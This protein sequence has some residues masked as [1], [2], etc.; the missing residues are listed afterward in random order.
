MLKKKKKGEEEGRFR[1]SGITAAPTSA[2]VAAT[3]AAFVKTIR[4]HSKGLISL[5]KET[6]KHVINNAGI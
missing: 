1:W 6:K 5:E 4:N 2:A 3:T